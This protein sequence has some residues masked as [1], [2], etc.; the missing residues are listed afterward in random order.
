MLV[1]L[2]LE[3]MKENKNRISADIKMK[4][5]KIKTGFVGPEMP[6]A[7]ANKTG[8]KLC[9]MLYFYIIG[10]WCVIRCNT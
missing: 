8:N 2:L 10:K 1:F 5:F 9:F 7:K 3:C 6:K 4:N